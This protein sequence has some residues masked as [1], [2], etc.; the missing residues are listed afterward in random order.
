MPAS[1]LVKEALAD[2]F[3]LIKYVDVEIFGVILKIL[4]KEKVQDCFGFLS[5]IGNQRLLESQILQ[6]AGNFTKTDTL[7][8]FF[9]LRK[10]MKLITYVL[11]KLKD[12]DFNNQDI[13]LKENEESK[14]SLIY[15]IKDNKQIQELLQFLVHLTSIDEAYIQGGSNSLHLLVKIK[16]DLRNKNFENIKIQNTCLVGANFGRCN[17]SGSQFNIVNTSGI[18]LNEAL[19]INCE[20]KNLRIHELNTLNGHSD[21]VGS[22]CF[23][24][25]G[26]TL[27]SGSGDKSIRLWDVKTGQQKAKLDGHMNSGED[28]Q[29]TKDYPN[30]G[31][32]LQRTKDYPNIG[33]DLQGTKDSLYMSGRW[34][35][36]RFLKFLNMGSEQKMRDFLNQDENAIKQLKIQNSERNQTLN[37]L[38]YYIDSNLNNISSKIT[39]EINLLNLQVQTII[40]VFLLKKNI[41]FNHSITNQKYNCHFLSYVVSISSPQSIY[42]CTFSHNKI[43]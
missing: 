15:S 8:K 33:G 23:S 30:S 7:Q 22:V 17:F 13:S 36:L 39:F 10:D 6:Q 26:N 16:V 12:H 29:G 4:R 27:V 25:D 42:Q 19:L 18:N 9:V 24:P 41:Q 5:D 32:D 28:L 1:F 3:S 31:G 11:K 40:Q 2:I 34:Y 37:Q 38:F 21:G 35:H 20:W 43:F 14:L